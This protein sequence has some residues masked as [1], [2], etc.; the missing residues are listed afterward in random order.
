MK[1]KKKFFVTAFLLVFT[2]CLTSFFSTFELDKTYCAKNPIARASSLNTTSS[3]ASTLI[4]IEA[5]YTDRNGIAV[6][7]ENRNS[8]V[9]FYIKA[10][11]SVSNV[12]VYWRTRD[13]S[14]VSST[15]DYEEMDTKY[16][17]NGTSSN[18]LYVNVNNVGAGTKLSYYNDDQKTWYYNSDTS[19]V[20]RNFFIEITEISS[21]NSDIAIDSSKKSI[22]AS[23]GYDYSFSV[24]RISDKNG[25][26]SYYFDVYNLYG[27]GR[28]QD[29]KVVTILS[30]SD[31]IDEAGKQKYYSQTGTISGTYSYTIVKN[32]LESGIAKAFLTVDATTYEDAFFGDSKNIKIGIINNSTKEYVCQ[33]DIEYGGWTSEY[34][35]P[36]LAMQ[37]S[38]RYSDYYGEV[39]VEPTQNT[40]NYKG[41]SDD[42][43]KWYQEWYEFK[44]EDYSQEA[45]AEIYSY[46]GATDRY[47]YDLRVRAKIVDTTAPEIKSYYLTSSQVKV[48][49]KVGLSVRFS[50]PVQILNGATPS[51]TAIINDNSMSYIDFNYVSGSGTDTLYFEWDP[52]TS[53]NQI[54]NT[55][56]NK[57]KLIYMNESSSI[58]DYAVGVNN[59]SGRLYQNYDGDS[60]YTNPKYKYYQEVTIDSE[61][62]FTHNQF[63]STDLST[64]LSFDL[65][66]RTPELILM[67]KVPSQATKY[68]EISLSLKNISTGSKFYYAWTTTDN[69]PSSYD[70]VVSNVSENYTIRAFDMDGRYFL[71]TKLESLYGKSIVLRVGSFIFD[72]SPPKIECSIT[73]TLTDKTVSLNVK[74]G[75]NDNSYVSGI[76]SVQL[77]VSRDSAGTDV[78]KTYSYTDSGN[79]SFS[80][81]IPISAGELGVEENSQETFYFFVVATDMV[82]NESKTELGSF[83]FDRRAYFNIDFVGA[84]NGS[85][86][87]VLMTLADSC[88]IIDITNDIKI[89]FGLSNIDDNELNLIFVDANGNSVDCSFT[90]NSS[91]VELSIPSSMSSGYYVL[92]FTSDVSGTKKYSNEISF[93]LTKSMNDGDTTYYSKISSGMLLA[94]RVYQ[95]NE[96]LV[97][98]YQ[99]K[100]GIINSQKYSNTNLAT[101]FSSLYEATQYLKFMEYQDLYPIVLNSTQADLLNG[102]SSPTFMKASGETMVAKENQIWIRYKISTFDVD[103]SSNQWAYYYYQGSNTTIKQEYLSTNLLSTIGTIAE[104]LAKSYGKEVNLVTSDY[105]NKYSE[106]ILSELQIHSKYESFNKTKCD[107]LFERTVIYDGDSNI[108]KSIF[109]EGG[110]EL[111]IATNLELSNEKNRRLFY[112]NRNSTDYTEIDLSKYSVLSDILKSSGVYDLIEFEG[113]GIKKFSVYI[114]KDAPE[115]IGYIQDVNGKTDIISFSKTSGGITYTAK[116]FTFGEISSTEKDEFAYVSVWKYST[117]ST[118]EL[119]NVYLRSDLQENSYVLTDGD[120]HIVVYDRSGNGYSFI[121][122]IN[123]QSF[124]CDVVVTEDEYI[125]VTCNRDEAQIMAYEIYLNGELLSS[126]YSQ[127]QRFNQSGSYKVV[128]RDIYNN[129]FVKEVSFERSY[130]TLDWQY[131]DSSV[132]EYVGY[133]ESSKK[134]QLSRVNETTIKITTSSLL[135]FK[136][137]TNFKYQFI[138]SVDYSENSIS[139]IVRINEL[140]AFSIKVSYAS[141]SDVSITYIIEVDNVAPTVVVKND[142]DVFELSEVEY[143]NK[144]LSTGNIGDIL[145]Y[146]SIG[147]IKRN[148]VTN[149]LANNDTVQSKLLKLNIS[150]NTG[151]SKVVIYVDDELFMNE[152]NNFTNIVLSKYGKYKIEAYDKFENKSVFEFTNKQFNSYSYYV[153]SVSQNIDYSGFD[154]FNDD[155]VFTKVEYGNQNVIL[156]LNGNGFVTF[157]LSLEKEYFSTLELA[158]GKIYFVTYKIGENDGTKTIVTEKS[159]S[160]FD[161]SNTDFEIDNWY[162][163][164]NSSNYGLNIYAKY[165]KDKNIFLKVENADDGVNSIECRTYFSDFE[166]YYFKTILSN[167]KTDVLIKNEDDEVIQTNQIEKQIKIN[168]SFH[169]VQDDI[170]SKQLV[171]IKVYYSITSNFTD[172]VFVYD[173]SFIEK[174][175]TESGL[176][177][178]EIKNIYGNIT[179]YYLSKYETFVVIVDSEFADGEKIEYS[180]NNHDTI[181]SNKKIDIFAYSDD[182]TVLIKKDN[183]DYS[184][185]VFSTE[186]GISIIS[187][188]ENGF[189]NVEITDEFGNTYLNTFEINYKS[190]EFDKDLIYGYNEDALRKDDGYTNKILS[191]LKDKVLEYEIKFISI[192]FD[193]NKTI[194]LDLISENKIALSDENLINSIGNLGNGVYEIVFRDKFGNAMPTQ[195]IHYKNDS[196]LVLTRS[197]RSSNTETAFDL[198]TALENGFWSNNVL[199][200]NTEATTYIFTIDGKRVECPYSITFTSGSDEGNFI[201]KVTYQDEYGFKY[202]FEAHLFRQSI[203]INLNENVKT[204]NSDG[205]LVT[206][207]DISLVF[208]NNTICSY[209]LNGINYEYS[210]N[211][212]LSKDGI[213]HFIVEDIAGN[214]SAL[215]IKKDSVVEYS[216]IEGMTNNVVLNGGIVCTNT[217]SFKALNGDSSYLKYV[218]KNGELQKD[219][220]DNKFTGSAKWEIVVADNVGNASYFTFQTITHKISKFD[221]T[222]P[223]GFV[224][225]EI[226]FNSGNDVPL[227]YMQYAVD[228]GRTVHLTENGKYSIVMTSTL[229]GEASSFSIT[230]S[231]F[232]PQIELV[233]CDENETTINDITIK[234]YSVGD[235]VEIYKNNKLIKTIEILTQTTDVPAITEGGEYKIVVTNEAGVQSSV[236]FVRKNIPNV[237]GNVLIIVVILAMVTVIFIGLVY[238]QRSKVDDWYI[239]KK[240]N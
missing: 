11:S 1:I 87:A 194:L 46:D 78:V 82:E 166:P 55:K 84:K 205:L 127:K 74:D 220:N 213:Y 25:R 85:S 90:R 69:E 63:S 59:F 48:G 103:P 49:D 101:T 238:R 179:K 22:I 52:S 72:T 27:V 73:G 8:K 160:L 185:F 21:E 197:T 157:K 161:Y 58:S 148:T 152:T 172:Y 118:G 218:F 83:K 189:Y 9:G 145:N 37:T 131:Y 184:N 221:Y 176:Y 150:D 24:D 30:K 140:K 208:T 126:K 23:S 203:E 108:Y 202:E 17:L 212:V 3:S 41:D 56:I 29:E 142:V 137:N 122:K 99:D 239:L 123:S 39:I 228:E 114:D 115:L 60:I 206:K 234:G 134:M 94:N 76:N 162:L 167:V 231:N 159:S 181:N 133:D 65:D 153:D 233:G 229:L 200:F 182:V 64:E 215:T 57:I 191:I 68:T 40:Y 130:P 121:L 226:W 219:Y 119:L 2:I 66:L 38:Y 95:L 236:S 44:V 45:C 98:Y 7:G 129:E 217:V 62:L 204:I 165:D 104:R 175:F 4:Y 138:E 223:Y 13:M 105:L 79:I 196:T 146:N 107:T 168:K 139:H 211:M 158:D 235:T 227:S 47:F 183:L 117:N 109:V 92:S 80:K 14:A 151:V 156:R 193:S 187:I 15:G 16:T 232:A 237:A 174:T 214:I 33:Y 163:I 32:Y 190:L 112:K 6:S 51:I 31:N 143:F 106:P 5:E 113:N 188:S 128:I 18:L 96:D 91:E 171:Y 147:Y 192:N 178:V 149:Y 88:K 222:V 225:T 240:L 180:A 230:I 89:K 224:I 53:S 186:K 75:E 195:T 111:Y 26:Y 216:L 199:K 201:Y 136:Y 198:K 173:G 77:I 120:Y 34:R 19:V 67:S 28:Q 155:G 141:Y 207:N 169:F 81:T 20:T 124:S 97:F 35:Y 100:N 86:D 116:L 54:A 70:T 110:E 209:T 102:K 43:H 144:Q 132:G 10:T 61:K 71:Y 170:L 210:G 125:T 50:E 36:I 135:Q 93:Y 177:L 12:T 164:L 154:Y 42:W